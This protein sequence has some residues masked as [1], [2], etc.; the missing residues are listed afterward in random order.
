MS[1]VYSKRLCPRKLQYKRKECV[2]MCVCMRV[3]KHVCVY[4]CI[5]KQKW[6]SNRKLKYIR[7]NITCNTWRKS[8]QN[9]DFSI[10]QYYFI[11]TTVICMCLVP[12][13]AEMMVKSDCCLITALLTIV[14]ECLHFVL[15]MVDCR[16]IYFQHCV[17][18]FIIGT[19]TH[20]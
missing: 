11:H 18:N 17:N 13:N 20:Q 10:S 7:N 9:G 12:L 3:F 5:Y 8:L 16:Y 19:V 4:M 1:V 15:R 6:F 14:L 2:C